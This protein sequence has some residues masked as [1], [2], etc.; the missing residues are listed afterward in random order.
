MA[1][2]APSALAPCYLYWFVVSASLFPCVS[3]HTHVC[4]FVFCF[5]TLLI[6]FIRFGFDSRVQGVL[7]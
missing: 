3:V 1:W 5:L 6:V 4:M 7:V 2:F